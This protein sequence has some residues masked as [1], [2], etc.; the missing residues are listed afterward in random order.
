MVNK[1]IIL[2]CTLYKYLVGTNSLFN[3][4]VI[5]KLRIQF[6]KNM[7]VKIILTVY[8]IGVHR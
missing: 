2:M 8:N 1:W 5:F 3:N 6:M 7:L 4:W